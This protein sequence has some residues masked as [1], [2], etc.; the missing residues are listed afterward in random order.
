MFFEFKVAE[1]ATVSNVASQYH[2]VI[3]IV[4]WG[5]QW[6]QFSWASLA[7][8]QERKKAT[9]TSSEI[10]VVSDAAQ[11]SWVLEC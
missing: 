6:E 10:F 8:R 1:E 7:P 5:F 11:A 2:W 9:A 3:G 4:P